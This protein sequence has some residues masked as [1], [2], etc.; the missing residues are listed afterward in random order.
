MIYIIVPVIYKL[1]FCANINLKLKQMKKLFLSVAALLIIGSMN[2]SA[3][4]EPKKEAEKKEQHK[5][6]KNE[7]KKEEKKDEKKKEPK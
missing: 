5:E 3:Q 2:V 1:L 7:K 6:K 4:Q